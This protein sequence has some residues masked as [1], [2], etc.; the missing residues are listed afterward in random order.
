MEEPREAFSRND[1]R[2]GAIVVEKFLVD[3]VKPASHVQLACSG[4]CCAFPSDGNEL[5]IWDTKDPPHQV[6]VT[7][8]P[9]ASEGPSSD[10]KSLTERDTRVTLTW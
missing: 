7:R 10:G 9:A 3:S 6:R 2:A 1:G 8:V 5:C 4:Q